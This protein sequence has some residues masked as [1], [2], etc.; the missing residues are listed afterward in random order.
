MEDFFCV[1]I[2]VTAS[3]FACGKG[4]RPLVACWMRVK[5]ENAL[6]KRSST[7]FI[8]IDFKA[9][10]V[11]LGQGSSFRPEQNI[12]PG[13]DEESTFSWGPNRYFDKCHAEKLT[14]MNALRFLM[15]ADFT[16]KI[17]SCLGKFFSASESGCQQKD[18]LWRK[19]RETDLSRDEGD[20][21]AAVESAK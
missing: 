10:M 7:S 17:H 16:K 5:D 11:P 14:D 15:H 13:V 2:A 3:V 9:P 19:L 12:N 18:E 6:H 20:F 8:G 21:C 1:P 4:I